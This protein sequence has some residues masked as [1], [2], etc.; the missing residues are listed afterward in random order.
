MLQFNCMKMTGLGA[1]GQYL[2]TLASCFH[3]PTLLRHQRA[4]SAQG[5]GRRTLFWDHENTMCKCQGP[6]NTGGVLILSVETP[7]YVHPN[8]GR[9][10]ER[11]RMMIADIYPISMPTALVCVTVVSCAVC[12][13][14]FLSKGRGSLELLRPFTCCFR[15]RPTGLCTQF[16]P[17]CYSTNER[18]KNLHAQAFKIFC[19][20]TFP[21]WS[22]PW[23]SHSR[24]IESDC[25]LLAMLLS[26][27]LHTHINNFSSPS[28]T[29]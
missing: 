16:C 9:E 17:H 20:Q 25:S 7:G 3:S 8:T 24:C 21:E 6:L 19:S 15:S 14:C 10:R 29:P 18:E 27:R 22:H 12:R 4:S 26:C 11:V 23:S 28:L 2:T 1:T 13:F 5:P